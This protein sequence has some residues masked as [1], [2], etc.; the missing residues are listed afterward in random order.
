M[1]RSWKPRGGRGFFPGVATA[2]FKRTCEFL[3]RVAAFY[4]AEKIGIEHNKKLRP[5]RM[6][7][8]DP[9][10]RPDSEGL[11]REGASP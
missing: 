9:N 2:R 10:N 4:R 1:A 7:F 11:E 8:P 5:G 3:K 6:N